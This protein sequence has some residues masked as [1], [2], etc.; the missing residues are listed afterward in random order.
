MIP[1]AA[2]EAQEIARIAWTPGT[3]AACAYVALFPSVVAYFLFNF[4]V[5][6]VGAGRAGQAIN[7][8]PVF[9]ALLAAV[10]L[11]QPPYGYHT[12]GIGLVAG[13][14]AVSWLSLWRSQTAPFMRS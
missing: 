11:P 5:A 9:G 14:I 8:M 12:A 2:T 4:A 1:L 6:E 3:I 10:L 13:G 7:L